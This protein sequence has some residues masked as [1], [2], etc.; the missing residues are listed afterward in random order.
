MNIIEVAQRFLADQK[1]RSVLNE[2]LL[3]Y[4]LFSII[5]SP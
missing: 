5:F 1:W 4:F 2:S 3:D